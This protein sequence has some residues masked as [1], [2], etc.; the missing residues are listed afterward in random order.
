MKIAYASKSKII[1]SINELKMML[2]HL[3][4]PA[5]KCLCLTVLV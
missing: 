2:W 3:N 4:R 1:G 5:H